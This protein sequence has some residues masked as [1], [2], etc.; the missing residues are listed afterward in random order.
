MIVVFQLRNDGEVAASG[1]NF[2]EGIG[3]EHEGQGSYFSKMANMK[4]TTE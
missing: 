3:T 2:T 1:K 4:P